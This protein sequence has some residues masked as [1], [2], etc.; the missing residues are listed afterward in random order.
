MPPVARGCQSTLRL[1]NGKTVM[2]FYD[3]AQR[4]RPFLR[5]ITFR[6]ILLSFRLENRNTQRRQSERGGERLVVNLIILRN[7]ASEIS[8]VAA[9]VNFRIAVEHFAPMAA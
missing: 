4:D 1:A 3:T 6:R 7:H 8:L 2:K 5:L 9:A